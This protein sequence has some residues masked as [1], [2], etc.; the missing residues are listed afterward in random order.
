MIV[1]LSRFICNL[2][3]HLAEEVFD[4]SKINTSRRHEP[5]VGIDQQVQLDD[6]QTPTIRFD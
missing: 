2:I 6:K 5:S 4:D 3:T 1:K